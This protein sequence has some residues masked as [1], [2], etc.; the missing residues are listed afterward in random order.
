MQ[1]AAIVGTGA[2]C[3]A[4]TSQQHLCRSKLVTQLRGRPSV[5]GQR[6]TLLLRP[7]A[8]G[9]A[10]DP[11][12]V[13]GPGA[14]LSPELRLAIEQFITENKVVAFIKG[15]KQFP[16]CGFSN[17]VVQ[18]LNS[19]GV[20]YVT[21]NVLEDDLLRGGMKEFSQWPT[22]PQVYIGAE[23]FGGADIMIASYTSGELS[24]TLEATMNA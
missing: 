16:Q 5:A 10:P 24:E 21:V 6:R 11:A 13:A 2:P 1:S 19:T 3:V 7:Q 4:A 22:F 14:G 9:Q 12:A 17:T 15:T 20:P 23:F 8:L 18:I